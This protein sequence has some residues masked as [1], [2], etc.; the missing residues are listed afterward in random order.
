MGRQEAEGDM[1]VDVSR[2]VKWRVQDWTWECG[3]EGGLSV[4]ESSEIAYYVY[5]LGILDVV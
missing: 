5:V 2:G 4:E 3:E 1:R